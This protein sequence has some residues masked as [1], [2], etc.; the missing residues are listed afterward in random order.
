[1]IR[2][3]RGW[4]KCIAKASKEILSCKTN[5]Y[6]FGSVIRNQF[7]GRS[8]VDILVVSKKLSF[9]HHF[10]IHL[11]TPEEAELYL[12]DVQDILKFE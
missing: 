5:I 4:I 7:T 1:M 12:K 9:I 8:D 11:V 3:W 10:E 6:V 2:N